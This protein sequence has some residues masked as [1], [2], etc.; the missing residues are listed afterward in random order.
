MA[1]KR[2]GSYLRVSNEKDIRRLLGKMIFEILTRAE[3]EGEELSNNDI[4]LISQLAQNILACL[5]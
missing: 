3:R 2:Y 5:K 1:K 4:R